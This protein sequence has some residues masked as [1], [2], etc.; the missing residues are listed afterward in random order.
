MCYGATD[1]PKDPTTLLKDLL[2]KEL[3]VHVDRAALRLFIRH[4]WDDFAPL[5]HAIHDEGK[6]PERQPVEMAG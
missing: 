5:A 4:H 6:E 1:A 2:A 3:N